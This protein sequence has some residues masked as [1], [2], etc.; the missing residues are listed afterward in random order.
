MSS[1]RMLVLPEISTGSLSSESPG[2]E[3]SD[4]PESIISI[5]LTKNGVYFGVISSNTLYIYQ[6]RVSI[7][8]YIGVNTMLLIFY[9]FV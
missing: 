7:S 2:I 3:F 4:I 6:V 5:K 1:P 8:D 9:S